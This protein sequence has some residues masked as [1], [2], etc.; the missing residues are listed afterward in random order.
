M[1]GRQALA[2][3]LAE[4]D[5]LAALRDADQDA[6][7]EGGDRRL[8]VGVAG[9]VVAVREHMV[10]QGLCVCPAAGDEPPPVHQPHPPPGVHD[11]PAAPAEWQCCTTQLK[12]SSHDIRTV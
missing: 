10:R 3:L 8:D 1:R 9:A 4:H 5:A 2:D 12:R 6:R 7:L 11:R